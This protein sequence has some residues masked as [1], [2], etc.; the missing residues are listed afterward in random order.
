[1]LPADVSPDMLNLIE[2][3]HLLSTETLV[4]DA[5]ELYGSLGMRVSSHVLNTFM[6]L[7]SPSLINA[8]REMHRVL[9][10][11]G[12]IGV[13]LWGEKKG[14]ILIWEAAC[15][16]VDPTFQPK[17]VNSIDWIR[18]EQAKVALY[19]VG[20]NEVRSELFLILFEVEDADTFLHFWFESQNPVA[21]KCIEQ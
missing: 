9:Q 14:P 1:M 5:S 18:P 4:L 16:K 7:Y 20:F 17:P 13:G 6:I 11:R 21:V 2:E 19:E 3:E 8:I 15:R 10:P 12:A